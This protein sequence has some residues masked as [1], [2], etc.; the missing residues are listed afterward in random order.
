MTSWCNGVTRV[1]WTQSELM[2]AALRDSLPDL[3]ILGQRPS[4]VG[5]ISFWTSREWIA[6]WY[7]RY[8][9]YQKEMC[10]YIYIWLCTCC[11]FFCNCFCFVCLFVCLVV[12]VIDGL[13]PCHLHPSTCEA[14]SA[15]AAASFV[16]PGRMVSQL[17]P[18]GCHQWISMVSTPPMEPGWNGGPKPTTILNP[19]ITRF[20]S[21]K[22]SQNCAMN[23]RHR[24]NTQDA[25]MQRIGASC[26][27]WR[28]AEGASH[29]LIGYRWFRFFFLLF[30][31]LFCAIFLQTILIFWMVFFGHNNWLKKDFFVFLLVPTQEIWH[32]FGTIF[33]ESL[34]PQT[35]YL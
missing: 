11:T 34:N 32:T 14:I 20:C 8:F 10:V 18:H 17:R 33:W 21:G 23:K 24:P 13:C 16:G 22:V 2:Q 27:V 31:H 25:A 5:I 29:P 30:F 9:W 12:V 28:R 3:L 1:A 19:K 35:S 4:A 15:A 6:G 26:Q 7:K